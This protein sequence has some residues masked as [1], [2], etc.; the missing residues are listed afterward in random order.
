[1]GIGADEYPYQ[2]GF[3]NEFASEAVPGALPV[4]PELAAAGPARPLRGAAQ[5]DRVHP[6]AR[7]EPADLGVPDHAVGR[8]P[9]VLARRRT[10]RSAAPPSTRSRPTRTGSAGTRSPCRR[11]DTDFID[12]L[13]TVAGNGDI[14]TRNG[15]AAHIYAANRSMTSRYFVDADGELL[16]VPEHGALALHTELGALVVAPGEIAVIPRGIRFR[17]ELPDGP[18]RGYLCENFGPAFTLPERGP[19]GSNGLANERDFLTPVA[20]YEDRG[21]TRAGRA[22][23]RRE[24]VGRRLRPLAAGRGRL[25]RELRAVQVRHRELHGDRDDQLRPPRPVDLHRAHLTQRAARPGERRLRDLPA[26]LAGG[27]GHLPPALVPPQHHVRVHGPGARRVRREGRGVRAGR[28]QPAQHVHLARPGR[29]DVRPGERGR[30]GAAEDRRHAGV[31]VREPLDDDPHQAGDGGPAPPAGLRRRVGRPD[32]FLP[33][34]TWYEEPC[35]FPPISPPETRW[36]TSCSPST[37]RP[38]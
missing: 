5:R 34:V 38:T 14:R 26:A 11:R 2:Q 12:G 1:M 20:R 21:R 37:A 25:A 7:G 9:E 23:V 19:I 8:A 33:G 22:E 6:A 4:G 30:A 29:R 15:M 18:V 24:P 16:F 36:W 31:H 3:G 17:V 13:Y 32:P 10:G 28:G 27:R 35:T